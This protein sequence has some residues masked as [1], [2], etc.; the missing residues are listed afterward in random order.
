[1]IVAWVPLNSRPGA[2]TFHSQWALP[3]GYPPC[4]VCAALP[5]PFTMF[6][7]ARD[8]ESDK[9][10]PPWVASEWEEPRPR[11]F[12]CPTCDA[13]VVLKQG[14]KRRAHFSHIGTSEHGCAR[15]SGRGQGE[16]EGDLHREVKFLLHHVLSTRR[17]SLHFKAAV[18][19]GCRCS[20]QER[21]LPL[22]PFDLCVLEHTGPDKTWRA[23][24]ALLDGT[25]TRIAALIE[26]VAS[27]RTSEDT[28]RNQG[29]WFEVGAAATLA[30][31]T[32]A[33]QKGARHATLTCLRTRTGESC[34][35]CEWKRRRPCIGC[36]AF[37][38]CGVMALVPC[39]GRKYSTAYVCCE[40]KGECEG[41]GTRIST[42][43]VGA[44]T[45]LCLDCG[46]RVDAV[47]KAV[48]DPPR[49]LPAI[50]NA[51]VK[52]MGATNSVFGA[53]LT[54]DG[55]ST[56]VRPKPPAATRYRSANPVPPEGTPTFL[57]APS[58][59]AEALTRLPVGLDPVDLL[60]P[61]D[62]RDPDLN[63]LAFLP[64]FA[65][66]AVAAPASRPGDFQHGVLALPAQ[67]GLRRAWAAVVQAELSRWREAHLKWLRVKR[68]WWA[69]NTSL[70][71]QIGR[72]VRAKALV[73]AA[74]AS[75]MP[76]LWRSWAPPCPVDAPF[77]VRPPRHHA[78]FWDEF[79]RMGR[80]LLV[81]NGGRKVDGK[82][83]PRATKWYVRAWSAE[84]DRRDVLVKEVLAVHAARTAT[85]EAQAA[86]AA[87]RANAVKDARVAALAEAF[88]RPRGAPTV[89]LL[90]RPAWD[91]SFRKEARRIGLRLDRESGTWFTDDPSKVVQ[92]EQSWLVNPELLEAAELVVM[93]RNPAWAPRKRQRAISDF[94][95]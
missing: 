51:D 10:V 91:T 49:D 35:K 13:R 5:D 95:V 81:V 14:P 66:V 77:Y 58:S 16:G 93:E 74:M 29:P 83:H 1:M 60:D 88:K 47:W 28:T 4:A 18:A 73:L 72:R 85:A 34:R 69:H 25:G 75:Q 87:A 22:P 21:I 90:P 71:V 79:W 62:L 11:G 41:C 53:V 44:P 7:S 8:V 54:Q 56:L 19:P 24:V 52:Y 68:H 36:G 39:R 42:R 48:A 65:P 84:L 55:L 80:L 40:C 31:L 67:E 32:A 92:C 82:L 46:D 30:A 38:D 20:R 76:R 33:S 17:M 15:F 89:H 3:P 50:I 86:R 70:A 64:L 27:H 37:A 94:S 45:P 43:T 23:D 26:V 2:A 12:Q 9:L 63:L 6:F 59:R 61:A 78:L 57:A